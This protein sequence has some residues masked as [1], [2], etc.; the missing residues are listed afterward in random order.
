MKGEIATLRCA[1]PDG[2]FAIDDMVGEGTRTHSG[3]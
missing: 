1:V 3:Q 2:Q